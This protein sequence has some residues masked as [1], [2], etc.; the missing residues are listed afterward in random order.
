MRR[1][2][3]LAAAIQI[4]P[5]G[6]CCDQPLRR[7]P[8]PTLSVACD[9]AA[10]GCLSRTRS[11]QDACFQIYLAHLAVLPAQREDIVCARKDGRAVALSCGTSYANVH[12]GVLDSLLYGRL[13]RTR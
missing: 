12:N 6:G 8:R 3:T 9:T 13:D 4:V 11:S 10:F 2:R 1:R 7:P 5:F